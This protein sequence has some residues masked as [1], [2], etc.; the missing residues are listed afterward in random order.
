V[1]SK[2]ALQTTSVAHLGVSRFQRLELAWPSDD[3]ERRAIA[4]ALDDADSLIESLE[5]LVAKK[6][7]IKQGAMQELLTGRRRLPR[8]SMTRG[9][10]VLT[11]PTDAVALPDI[12]EDWQILPLKEVGR[13]F[14]GGTPSMKEP[15][16]WEGEISWASPKDMKTSRIID[17]ADHIADRAIVDGTRVLP[18]GAILLVIRGM[19]LAHTLPVARAERH[20]AFN[21]DIKALVVRDDMDSEYVLYWLLCHSQKLLGLATESTHG[22]KR[23]PPESLYRVPFPTPPSKAEQSAIA[24][25]LSDIDAEITALE[26]KLSKARRVKQGMMQ[27]L[28]TGRIRLV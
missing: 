5:R 28:L 6:R 17:T 8:F 2:I 24:S 20:V 10:K 27:S 13:W 16:Y 21:Q 12:P 25:V 26:V 14:S 22:T 3:S 15:A 1:F 11:S 9:R 18:A 19:I 7:L 4:D 23:L